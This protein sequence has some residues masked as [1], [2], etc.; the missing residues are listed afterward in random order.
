MSS[1]E[2]TFPPERPDRNPV[3]GRF[4]PG[5]TPANKGRKWDEYMTAK[6]KKRVAVGWR[7]LDPYNKGNRLTRRIVGIAPSGKWYIFPSISKASEITGIRRDNINQCCCHSKVS[8]TYPKYTRK[9]AGGWHWFYESDDA[10]L[11]LVSL[12]NNN[13]KSINRL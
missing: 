4:L 6:S 1:F 7:N 2:L 13:S 8:Q 9:T 3:T 12:G 10:W 5:H 11:D